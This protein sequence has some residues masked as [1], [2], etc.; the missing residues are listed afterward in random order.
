[1]GMV[2]ANE[3]IANREKAQA[4]RAAELH[5]DGSLKLTDELESNS[6]LVSRIRKDWNRNRNDKTIVEKRLLDALRARKGEYSPGKIAEIR[7]AGASEMYIKLTTAKVRTAIAHL[8]SVM[9]PTGGWSH[10]IKP[11][12]EPSM[13]GWMAQQAAE[14]IQS[15]PAYLDEQGNPVEML[16]QTETLEHMI[17]VELS[18]KAKH[19]ARRMERKIYDQLQE[20]D[21]RNAQSDFIDDFCTFQAAF[22]KGPFLVNK[23]RLSWAM[24]EQGVHEPIRVIEPVMQ[25]RTIDPF[26]AYP[27]PGVDSVHKGSFCE[28]LRLSRDDLYAMRETPEVYDT[29]AIDRVIELNVNHRL[30]NWL[31]TDNS[32]QQIANHT[33]FWYASSTDFD[34]IHWYGEALG[35]ELI[36]HGVPA[37]E[38]EDLN[39][40]YQIDAIL[41][42]NEVIKATLNRDP[43]YR[44]NISSSCYE[45]IPGAVFGN[46]IADL[47]EDSQ[48]MVNSCGRALQNNLAHA[49][50]FQIEVDYT[51]LHPNTDPNDIYPFKVWQG[52]ESEFGGDRPVVKFFQPDSNA[53]ELIAV[54]QQFTEQADMDSGIP[55]FM[56]GGSGEGGTS[57][58]ARG[59][60]M[61]KDDS[62]KLLRSAITNID[63]D[64]VTPNIQFVYDYNMLYDQDASIKG[65]SQVCA[66]GI[67]AALQ[68]EGAR[69]QHMAVLDILSNPEDRQLLGDDKRF[70]I[71]RNMLDTF[72]EIDTDD[73]IPSDDEIKYRLEQIA[74]APPPP[75]PIM[76]KIAADSQIAQAKMELE[77]EKMGAATEESRQKAAIELQK[78]NMQR[79]TALAVSR[80]DLD[81]KMMNEMIKLRAARHSAFEVGQMELDRDRMKIEARAREK[82]QDLRNQL[83]LQ[84]QEPDKT[85]DT[86]EDAESVEAAVN[87]I[88]LPLIQDFK[89]ETLTAIDNI[90]KMVNDEAGFA[91]DINVEVNLPDNK[92]GAKHISTTR[93]AQGNL[94]ATIRPEGGE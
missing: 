93:D 10:G 42:G 25:W 53:S 13:P 29:D 18:K 17:R 62:A 81:K 8:K 39:R 71:I 76:E 58:T 20:G 73:I 4:D 2:G 94:Q 80:D 50:G 70:N 24:T 85:T 15:N 86:P 69:Q 5:G 83:T 28:R 74:A 67:H 23:P 45:K 22:M 37:S 26:D 48:Q 21:W 32:R 57:S 44:R 46:A 92:P 16:Q 27:A 51:R 79:E 1:M 56:H 35:S 19:A 3:V 82:V 52:K 49:S 68:R 9:M 55:R 34:G 61:M 89:A 90:A 64:M 31:W 63:E 30:D 84:R 65:D 88:L 6:Q 91:G 75:D 87:D 38:V 36:E 78:A 40:P 60:A 41:I 12:K 7:T 47:M 33:F 14:Y 66:K 77:R 72:E 54:M 59:A 43:L 11:T